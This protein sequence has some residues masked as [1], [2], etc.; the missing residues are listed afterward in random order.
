MSQRNSEYERKPRD[1]YET[2]TWVTEALLELEP[3]IKNYAVWEPACA[4]GKMASVLKA[5][6]ATDLVTDYG[7]SGINFLEVDEIY[8]G[9][10]AI[11]TNPPFNREAEN[12]IRHGIDFLDRD[13]IQ[14]MAML[15]PVDFDSA[16]TRADMFADC[17]WFAGKIVLTSRIIWFDYPGRKSGPSQNHCWLIWDKNI[18]KEQNEPYLRYHFR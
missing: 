3:Q 10:N 4:S 7:H 13:Q 8:D 14:Y 11:I 17:P 15:L 12:F 2:P 9:M 16:K 6:M 18:V 5:A 1:L